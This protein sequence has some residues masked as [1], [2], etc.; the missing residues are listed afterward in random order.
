[1]A[2]T[3][4]VKKNGSPES[5]KKESFTYFAP[6]AGNVLLVGDFTGWEQQPIALKKN[7]D[8]TWKATVPL[9]PGVHE[10]R[11]NVWNGAGYRFLKCYP[12]EITDQQVTVTLPD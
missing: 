1:M 7:K 5:K 12:V 9:D 8:G 3:T 6:G 4:A 11:F 10:Y 2:K